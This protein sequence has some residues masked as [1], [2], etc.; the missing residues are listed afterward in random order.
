V[1]KEKHS[2]VFKERQKLFGVSN[3]RVKKLSQSVL[4]RIYFFAL[5]LGGLY[6][7]QRQGLVRQSYVV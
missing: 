3:G 5:F 7:G 2:A 1:V 4:L 6:D